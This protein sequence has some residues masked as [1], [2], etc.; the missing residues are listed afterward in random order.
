MAE[1]QSRTVEGAEVQDRGLFDFLG[2]KKEEKADEEVLASGVEKI[3]IEEEKPE[4]KKHTL[5]DKLH[6]DK[7][8][9]EK[10]HSLLDKL[11]HSGSSSSSSSSDEEGADEEKKER[12]RKKKGLK[13]KV[14]EKLHGD[15]KPEVF[16]EVDNTIVVEKVEAEAVPEE[17]K[18]GFLEKIKEKLPGHKKTIEEEA[19]ES[20]PPPPPAP[21]VSPEGEKK[22]FLAKIKEKLPGYHKSGGEEGE[23]V[24]GSE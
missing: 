15:D 9:E 22:G 2:K 18:K 13:E 21:V 4:E 6:E 20:T 8:E 1:E 24:A 23:K 7:P 11:H 3:Q 12:R 17:E 10:K 16:E 5:F 19:A 14:E